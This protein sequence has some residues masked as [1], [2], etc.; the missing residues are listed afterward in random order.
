MFQT[1]NAQYSSRGHDVFMP[2]V[3]LRFVQYVFVSFM[4]VNYDN[5]FLTDKWLTDT[6]RMSELHSPN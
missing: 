1:H 4:Y 2:F 3:T 6:V 5:Y